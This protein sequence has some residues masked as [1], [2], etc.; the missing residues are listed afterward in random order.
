MIQALIGVVL[1][2][3]LATLVFGL[4][5]GRI[6]WRQRGCCPAD[7]DDDLRMRTSDTPSTSTGTTRRRAQ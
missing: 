2:A 4:V 1:A 5:T 6:A 3:F 7:P